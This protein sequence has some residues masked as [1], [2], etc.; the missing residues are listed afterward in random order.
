MRDDERMFLDPPGGAAIVGPANPRGALDF[1]TRAADAVDGAAI[2]AGINHGPVR[3]VQTEPDTVVVGDGIA[4][5]DAI[6]DLA[7]G[8]RLI[9]AREFRDALAHAAPDR[10][11]QLAR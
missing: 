5:A 3:V 11:R 7:P 9:A 10:A 2:A 4:A 8:G 1:A 6:V